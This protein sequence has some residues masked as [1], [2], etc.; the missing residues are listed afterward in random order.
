M[1]DSTRVEMVTL[2]DEIDFVRAYLL[3]EQARF[4]EKLDFE[5]ELPADCADVRL[6]PMTLQ[7]IVENAVRHGIGGSRIGGKVFISVHRMND[8][9]DVTVR[10]TGTGFPLEPGATRVGDGVGID[11]VRSRLQL[12]CGE[13]ADLDVQSRTGTGTTVHIRIPA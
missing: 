10:D 12:A 7:P 13:R 11:N 4:E 6:P 8:I 2:Q 5:L 1:L 9:V 3:I